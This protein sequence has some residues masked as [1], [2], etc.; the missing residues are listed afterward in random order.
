MLVVEL[1]L[2][3]IKSYVHVQK[4]SNNRWICLFQLSMKDEAFL[5]EQFRKRCDLEIKQHCAFKKTKFVS[6]LRRKEQRSIDF[7]LSGI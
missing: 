5:S 3:T 1:V 2:N 4:S 7:H 6:E